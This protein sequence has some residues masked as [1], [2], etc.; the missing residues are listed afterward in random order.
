MNGTPRFF[1]FLMLII[2]TSC[3]RSADQEQ[4]KTWR[5]YGGGNE[6][7]RYSALTQVDT[8]NVTQLQKAWTYHTGDADT[9][10]NSQIQHNPIIIGNTLYG[11][12][13]RMKL[14][15]LNAATGQEQWVF[16][17]LPDTT[18][19]NHGISNNRGVAYWQNSDGSEQR[20]LY[21]AGSKLYSIDATTGKPDT[22]FAENGSLPLTEGLGLESDNLYVS[23]TSP[24]IVYRDTF[25]LGS[26]VSEG[27]DAAPGDIRAFNVRTGELEWTFHT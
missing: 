11:V 20:I 23:A 24:G 10:K 21:T 3:T 12:T 25:I 17:P 6:S 15:A 19:V 4:Y 13:P 9:A 8:S 26:R 18:E 16:N 14:F 7:I 1:L 27:A 2:Y 5:V 22:S